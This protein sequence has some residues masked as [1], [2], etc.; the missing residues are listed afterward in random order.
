MVYKC[1]VDRGHEL[2]KQIFNAASYIKDAA[3]LHKVTPSIAEQV[4]TGCTLKLMAAI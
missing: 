3:V 4:R 1:K 2:L